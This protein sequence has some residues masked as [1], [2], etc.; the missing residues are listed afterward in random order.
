[1]KRRIDEKVNVSV[2]ISAQRMCM[3]RLGCNGRGLAI[4]LQLFMIEV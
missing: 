1:M 2:H 3:R 4:D